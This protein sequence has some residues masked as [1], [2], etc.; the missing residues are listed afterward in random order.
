[1]RDEVPDSVSYGLLLETLQVRLSAGWRPDDNRYFNELAVQ[2][3]C[4]QRT[5]LRQ[6]A[7]RLSQNS[8]LNGWADPFTNRLGLDSLPQDQ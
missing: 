1:M 5:V 2:L 8:W 6:A 7:H 3:V 4:A